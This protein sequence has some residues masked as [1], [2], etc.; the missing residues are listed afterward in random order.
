LG[1]STPLSRTDALGNT[2]QVRTLGSGERFEVLKNYPDRDEIG[3]LLEGVAQRVEFD[4]LDYYW[5]LTY[6][7]PTP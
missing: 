2:Y 7:T 6:D 4:E 3:G 1:N 5:V